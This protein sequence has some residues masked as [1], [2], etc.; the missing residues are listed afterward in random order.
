MYVGLSLVSSATVE[1]LAHLSKSSLV[2]YIIFFC[3][4]GIGTS[5]TS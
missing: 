4:I 5:F 3:N 2:G 1:I